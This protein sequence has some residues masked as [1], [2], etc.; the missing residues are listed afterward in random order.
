MHQ[1]VVG[2][3]L[4]CRVLSRVFARACAGARRSSGVWLKMNRGGWGAQ[5][6]ARVGD[7]VAS[8]A[9]PPH[10]PAETSIREPAVQSGG[11]RSLLVAAERDDAEEGTAGGTFLPLSTAPSTCG[12][13]HNQRPSP[14]SWGCTWELLQH[15]NPTAGSSHAGSRG[16]YHNY[17]EGAPRYLLHNPEPM[18]FLSIGE[19]HFLALHSYCCMEQNRHSSRLPSA[20]RPLR[21]AFTTCPSARLPSLYG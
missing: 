5:N 4:C 12:S 18:G 10:R 11:G 15:G 20:M 21:T 19:S 1:R 6:P 9:R 3:V 17:R 8:P 14:R 7:P 13:T 2:G 16:V